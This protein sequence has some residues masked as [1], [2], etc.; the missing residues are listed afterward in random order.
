MPISEA[1]RQLLAQLTPVTNPTRDAETVPGAVTALMQARVSA[2]RWHDTALAKETSK[3]AK[4]TA[5]HT[6]SRHGYQTGWEAQLWRLMT[7]ETPDQPFALD[8]VRALITKWETSKDGS[9]ALPTPGR[10]LR[11]AEADSTG[12]FIGPEVEKQAIAFAA[13][14]TLPLQQGMLAE[15]TTRAGTSFVPYKYIEIVMQTPTRLAGISLVR[16]QKQ[17]KRS[18]QEF[19]E[20]LDDFWNRGLAPDPR[21]GAS[22]HDEMTWRHIR[23][24]GTEIPAKMLPKLGIRF[25]NLADLLDYL[26]VTP[27]MM[28]NVRLVL[29]RVPDNGTHWKL[30]TAYPVNGST[31]LRPDAPGRWTGRIEDGRGEIRTLSVTP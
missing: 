15:M 13:N 17:P 1:D 10:N 16:D 7:G 27:V 5:F 31:Q 29:K 25:P 14:R 19:T 28:P 11:Y 3:G 21:K 22:L 23:A 26:H 18:R 20:A 6:L 9:K 30:H 8:G 12:A 24:S 4:Q 2:R